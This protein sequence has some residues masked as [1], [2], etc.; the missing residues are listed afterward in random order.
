MRKEELLKLLDSPNEEDRKQAIRK[1]ALFASD[2]DVKEK[3]IEVY[4]KETSVAVK[5]F[6]RK[7]LEKLGID[8]KKIAQS[9]RQVQLPALV[10]KLI[11]K[12]KS[13]DENE[14]VAAIKRLAD[15]KF[16][17][18]VDFL[19][20]L[21]NSENRKIRVYAVQSLGLLRDK[22][23]LQPLIN[24]VEVEQDNFVKATLV[25]ALARLGGVD[26]IKYIV[27]Y[28]DDED[29]RVRANAVEA[30][31]IV[32]LPEIVK[33]LIPKLQDPEPRVRANVVRVLTK[34]G[35]DDVLEELEKMLLSNDDKKV[36][37]AFF[38]IKNLDFPELA[39]L[40]LKIADKL[41]DK[42]REELIEIL[43]KYSVTNSK[44][45]W[46]LLELKEAENNEISEKQTLKKDV[47]KEE[48]ISKNDTIIDSEKINEQ[49]EKIFASY[50]IKQQE[51]LKEVGEN[52]EKLSGI[53]KK[54]VMKRFLITVLNHL[55]V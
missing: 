34:F 27:K 24:L 37:T 38:T 9:E 18:V 12:A 32:N 42:Y 22:K 7:I 48:L 5:Y 31:E 1:V 46:K 8:V 29:P 21:L 43:E 4:K 54:E 11:Q 40:I 17:Q 6:A 55:K 2:A 14:A 33:Y 47:E 25:K 35:R 41:K 52:L 49:V 19:I 51:I 10:T 20:S 13:Q 16:P 23:A 50:W 45:K 30:L 28:L 44:V 3:I 36:R 26:E 39:E 53:D 15:F